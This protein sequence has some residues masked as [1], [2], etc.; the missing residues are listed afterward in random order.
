VFN[1]DNINSASDNFDYINVKGSRIHVY[2]NIEF[3]RGSTFLKTFCDSIYFKNYFQ[4][5][6]INTT[7]FYIV[8]FDN[9]L[10]IHKVRIL[11]RPSYEN[12]D[13]ETSNK[14]YFE[15]I[16]DILLKTNGKWEKKIKLKKG[17]RVYFG[18]IHIT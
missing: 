10:K 14:M 15:I 1:L 9:K 5:H 6:E 17:W 2:K 7:F 12:T 4:N 3:K 8:L 18:N 13:F 16:E 11:R